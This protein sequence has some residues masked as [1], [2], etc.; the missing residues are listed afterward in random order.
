MF[1]FFQ[2]WYLE[3]FI[4]WDTDFIYE[5]I[6]WGQYLSASQFRDISC[7]Q[8]QEPVSGWALLTDHPASVCTTQLSGCSHQEPSPCLWC[9]PYLL[10]VYCLNNHTIPPA[11]QIQGWLL[12]STFERAVTV[13]FP[14]TQYPVLTVGTG[15]PF[16]KHW[17]CMPVSS[18]SA[19]SLFQLMLQLGDPFWWNFLSSQAH[20]Q[21][22]TF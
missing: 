16:F 18:I 8:K 14:C 22:I 3:P 19:C 13:P 11:F 12:I 6:D 17:Y 9:W 4:R 7:K 5:P 20:L 1:I 15:L 21:F 10:A 2:P